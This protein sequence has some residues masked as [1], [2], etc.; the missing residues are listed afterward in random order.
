MEYNSTREHLIIPEY[1]R[2]IQKM[3]EHLLTIE[4]RDR[5]TRMAHALISIMAQVQSQPKDAGDFRQKLWDH[6]HIISGLT[7]D[8]DSPYPAPNPET[9]NIKPERLPYAV[10][11]LRFAQYGKNIENIIQKVIDYEE[12]PEKDALIRLIANHLK[13]SYLNWNRDS[14]SDELITDHLALLS[15]NKLKLSENARLLNT[16]D[17]LARPPKKKFIPKQNGQNNNR[18]KKQNKNKGHN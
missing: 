17:I 8:V 5:R 7:L 1:G 6:L 10:K 15:G 9:L 11:D 16:S 14:V 18:P 12:G 3:I 13:K 2:N 4:D